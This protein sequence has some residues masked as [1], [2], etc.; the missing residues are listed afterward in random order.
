MLEGSHSIPDSTLQALLAEQDWVRRL[1]RR[2]VADTSLA[3]D[4]AQAT[5]LAALRHPPRHE[6]NLRA[7]LGQLVVNTTRSTL[8]S[9]RRR[10]VRE[11]TWH[12]ERERESSDGEELEPPEGAI[13]RAELRAEL[14]HLVKKLREPYRYTLVRVIQEDRTSSEVAREL[15]LPESTVRSHVKRGLDMIR[16]EL[17]KAHRGDERRGADHWLSA[18]VFIAKEPLQG[19]PPIP[20]KPPKPAQSSEP[21]NPVEKVAT[22]GAMLAA[23]KAKVAL[24]A[25]LALALGS[26]LWLRGG[27][28]EARSAGGASELAGARPIDSSSSPVESTPTPSDR[29]AASAPAPTGAAAAPGVEEGTLRVALTWESNGSPASRV[30]VLVQQWAEN[31]SIDRDG[32]TGEDGT[33]T[34]DHL[35][36]GSAFVFVDRGGN[37]RARIESGRESATKI[38]IPKGLELRGTVVDA[39]FAPVPGAAIYLTFDAGAQTNQVVTQSDS[40]GE[41][42]IDSVE[43]SRYVGA[44]KSG[45]APSHNHPVTVDGVASENARLVLLGP[46]G[47]VGGVVSRPDGAPVAHAEVRIG[48]Q[49]KESVQLLDHRSGLLATARRIST[50]EHG[51]FGADDLAVGENPITVDARGFA[52][53]ASSVNVRCDGKANVEI[54]LATQDADRDIDVQGIVSDSRGDP[55]SAGIVELRALDPDGGRNMWS[56]RIGIDGSY[57][58]AGV[59]PGKHRITA[60]CGDLGSFTETIEIGADKDTLWNATVARGLTLGGT[61]LDEFGQPLAGWLISAQPT[62]FYLK[63]SEWAALMNPPAEWGR[64]KT[65]ADGRFTLCNL[66]DDE[67]RVEL[68][69]PSDLLSSVPAAAIEARPPQQ[70]LVLRAQPDAPPS[71]YLIGSVFDEDEGSILDANIELLERGAGFPRAVSDPK[72][73]SFKIGPLPAGIYRVRV[74]AAGFAEN[75]AFPVAVANGETAS[76]GNFHLQRAGSLRVKLVGTEGRG[77]GGASVWLDAGDGRGAQQLPMVGD[78][79]R[80]EGLVPGTYF[81]IVRGADFSRLGRPTSI[82]IVAGEQRDLEI[83]LARESR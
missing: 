29:V 64:A 33:V 56:A 80:A 25:L 51:R 11:D 31:R 81:V 41:F 49:G 79:A 40:K 63:E 82:K 43:P 58:V 52:H 78:S 44:R 66:F 77:F 34:I 70:D 76:V 69:R 83:D 10:I 60:D 38:A 6:R 75:V 24:A 7:W 30:N 16:N 28:I 19:S 59:P 12:R 17:E 39:D 2:L 67:W 4:I 48:V 27:S 20:S 23:S 35:A 9:E 42:T 61:A 62:K 36:P 68:R 5:W 73:G 72:N 57:R 47:G 74:S 65:D 13:A 54:R 71:S 45:F 15:D 22:G 37:A 14:A 18:L 3:D 50:D 55:V 8:R 32:I 1:A 26:F 21:S 46:G 53:Y